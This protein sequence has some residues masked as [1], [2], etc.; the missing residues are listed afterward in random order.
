M[1]V[2]FTGNNSPASYTLLFHELKDI[3][4]W[5]ILC[6][7]LGVNDAI[8]ERIR[9]DTIDS[10]LKKTNCLKAY[11]DSG[12]ARWDKVVRVVCSNPFYNMILGQELATKYG[13]PETECSMA[14]TSN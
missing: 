6:T 13:V 10:V 14:Y 7:T 5:D 2:T 3:G 8:M 9:Y 11:I 4:N 1:Y 12:K